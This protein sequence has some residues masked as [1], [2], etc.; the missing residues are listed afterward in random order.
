MVRLRVPRPK[1]APDDLEGEQWPYTMPSPEA[2]E[3]GESVWS[4]WQ[5]ASRRMDLAFAPTEPSEMAPLGDDEGQPGE[6]EGA[7]Q[8]ADAL[9]VTARQNNRVCPQ[10]PQWLRLYEVLEGHLHEDLRPPPIQARMWRA[11]SALQKRLRFREHIEWA[12]QHGC[13]PE[14]AHFMHGL[15]ESDWVHMGEDDPI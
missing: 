6:G 7:W 11:L 10:Q 9:M 3:G 4:Q 13:L 15:A 12:E 14:V 5:E 8:S 1:P 2:S